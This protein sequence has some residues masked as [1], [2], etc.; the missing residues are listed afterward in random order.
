MIEFIVF[1]I[2]LFVI[3]VISIAL[4]LWI[5]KKLWCRVTVILGGG[6]LGGLGGYF[7]PSETGY[8]S[9]TDTEIMLTL[10]QVHV[11]IG[12]AVGL[13]LAKVLAFT[14]VRREEYT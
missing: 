5:F 4:L 1:M 14:L 11:I 13:A 7:A 9:I 10:D 8:I 6:L 2:A 3:P 12:V